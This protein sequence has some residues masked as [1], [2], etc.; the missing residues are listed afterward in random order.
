M[1]DWMVAVVLPVS[2]CGVLVCGLFLAALAA[3]H[4]SA[5]EVQIIQKETEMRSVHYFNIFI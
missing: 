4:N 1:R 2:S 5:W 3:A